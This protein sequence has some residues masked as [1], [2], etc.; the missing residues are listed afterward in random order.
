MGAMRSRL[1][2]TLVTLTVGGG[3]T[4]I[5]TTTQLLC[6]P[7]VQGL[8]V[9]A[10]C[11][12]FILFSIFVLTSGLLLVQNPRRTKALLVALV[13]QIPVVSSPII[14]Y[15]FAAGLYA[16]VGLSEP[17]LNGN[18]VAVTF[19]W[20]FRLGGQWQFNLL[21]PLPWSVGLNIVPIFLLCALK[22]WAFDRG[23]LPP[24][25]VSAI[26]EGTV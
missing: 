21:Q 2:L 6:S 10:I 15:Q 4:C 20:A 17:G 22:W 14:A 9:V 26:P 18:G 24:T 23:E 3:F 25:P 16:A 7:Q 19:W 13:L 12:A 8:A 11:I 1:R 5:A